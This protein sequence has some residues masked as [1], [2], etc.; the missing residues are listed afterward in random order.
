M[1]QIDPAALRLAMDRSGVTVSRLASQTGK[2]LSY[3]SDICSGR[4]NLARNPQLR[5][6]IATT[7]GV[8]QHWIER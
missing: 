4:R 7:L 6:D 8:P 3:M 5:K 2:S 1:P